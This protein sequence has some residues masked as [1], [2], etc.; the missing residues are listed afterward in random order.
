MRRSSI[1]GLVCWAALL[2]PAWLQAASSSQTEV[3][4]ESM[5]SAEVAAAV[6]AGRTTIIIPV[7]GTEQSGP[8][9]ALGK[10]NV[11]VHY[12]AG[13]I[14]SALGNA[15]V[16]PVVSYVPEGA[17]SPPSGHMR[18][19]GT[20]SIPDGAF[21]TLLEAAGRSFKQHGFRDIVLLGDHGGYQAQLRDVVARLNRAWAGSATRAHFIADYYS[22]AQTEFPK[23]LRAQGLSEEQIG[24]HG[25]SA[26][27]SLTLAIHPSLV[28]TDQF[29]T[30]AQ[31]GV[32]VGV[33]GDPRPSTAI[34]GQAGVDLIVQR[35]VAA[36]RR[37][38]AAAR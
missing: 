3:F 15:L 26:D 16:A 33:E 7:G 1:L 31:G 12:L 6:R 28:R 35:S 38:V 4:L 36:I 20:I 37:A 14:A 34:L 24:L 32:G 19:A 13:K 2:T 8:H 25:G 17:I 27:T 23:L 29:G 18:F 5:T 10:H 21:Q 30:A 11:R 22:A 9:L